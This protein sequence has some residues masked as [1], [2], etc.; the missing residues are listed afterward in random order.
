M[1][2]LILI[3]VSALL[4]GCESTGPQVTTDDEKSQ[5][6]LSAYDGYLN[7]EYS[8]ADDLY[9]DDVTVYINSVEAIDKQANIAG[10]ASHHDLFN[11]ISISSPGGEG[12]AYVQTTKYDND[13]GLWSHAWFIWGGTGKASGT[14]VKIPCHVAYQWNEDG[15]IGQTWLFSDQSPLLA[16]VNAALP[17]T[18]R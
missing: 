14:S 7:N 5:A 15:S 16:E 9:S 11:D 1:K 13:L 12:G 6:I 10:L 2:N 4:L 3:F 17:V 8:W 18:K